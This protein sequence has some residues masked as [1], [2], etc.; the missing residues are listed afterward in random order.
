MADL[1]YDIAMATYDELGQSRGGTATGGSTTTVAD[2]GLLG[3]DDD[4]NGGMVMVVHSTDSAAPESEFGKVTDY[5]TADGVITLAPALSVACALG[6]QYAVASGKHY[7]YEDMLRIINRTLRWLGP[8][9]VWDDTSL[10]TSAATTEFTLPLAA[11]EDL[12]QVWISTNSTTGDRRWMEL[13]NWYV[14]PDGT[15]G[16]QATLVLRSQP[17]S[18]QDLGLL[19]LT[20]HSKLWLDSDKLLEYCPMER[21]IAEVVVN[22]FKWKLGSKSGKDSLFVERINIAILERDYARRVHPIILPQPPHKSVYTTDPGRR[23]NKYGPWL[24]P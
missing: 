13:S 10:D 2:T 15:A 14:Q 17:D 16:T 5:T 19:Y 4:W 3:S 21:I 20:K 1:L 22:L 6:D 12:R 23:P 8:F 11:K 24:V 7:P 9:P 18:G